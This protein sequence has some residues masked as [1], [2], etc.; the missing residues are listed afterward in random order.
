MIGVLEQ[1][2]QEL[3][4]Q[5]AP[6]L[7]AHHKSRHC[8]AAAVPGEWACEIVVHVYQA[9]EAMPS[10]V[11]GLGAGAYLASFL[12]SSNTGR[13][14]KGLPDTAVARTVTSITLLISYVGWSTG[15]HMEQHSLGTA[16]RLICHT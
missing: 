16:A 4:L 9:L 2:H 3:L 12:T 13:S 7:Q 14:T 5:L 15:L 10:A 1:Q 6:E 11:Q 8:Q